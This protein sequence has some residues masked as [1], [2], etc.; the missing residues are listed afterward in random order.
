MN[1]S[2]YLT[3]SAQRAMSIAQQAAQ[4]RGHHQVGCVYLLLGLISEGGDLARR[5]LGDLGL[6]T[7]HIQALIEAA[8]ENPTAPPGDIL[9]AAIGESD[10][11]GHD[12]IGVEHLLLGLLNDQ[13]GSETIKQ[14]GLSPQ[15]VRDRLYQLLQELPTPEKKGEN[16]FSVE[17]SPFDE[18]S[19]SDFILDIRKLLGR[20]QFYLRVLVSPSLAFRLCTSELEFAQEAQKYK[21]E[22]VSFLFARPFCY[23]APGE[24]RPSQRTIVANWGGAGLGNWRL[25]IPLQRIRDSV[26]GEDWYQPPPEFRDL[27]G[28]SADLSESQVIQWE[29]LL[30][31]ARWEPHFASGLHFNIAHWDGG[32]SPIGWAYSSEDVPLVVVATIGISRADLVEILNSLVVL[33]QADDALI[34]SLQEE[35]KNARS[36]FLR[37]RR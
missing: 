14:L 17:G 15:Q 19:D 31:D 9:E 20:C 26:I 3:G 8:G 34:D 10:R 30:A 33:Q 25:W 36:E 18:F 29:Q 23:A 22:R 28:G 6:E 12:H 2:K 13:E 27:L 35:M 1:K 16:G 4:Q 5:A 32:Q 11:L 37:Y 24:R 7:R 21:F